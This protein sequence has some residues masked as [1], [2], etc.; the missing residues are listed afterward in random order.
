MFNENSEFTSG[1]LGVNI[2]IKVNNKKYKN[3]EK[4][5]RDSGLHSHFRRIKNTKKKLCMNYN[6]Y[7]VYLK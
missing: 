2:K 4:L 7:I 5:R 1:F 6:R 3:I